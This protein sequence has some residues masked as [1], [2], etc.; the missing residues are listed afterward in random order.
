MKTYFKPTLVAT[1][2]VIAGASGA[3]SAGPL[4]QLYFQQTSTYASPLIEFNGEPAIS[5]TEA[6]EL[7]SWTSN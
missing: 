4:S 7:L 6:P 2:L 3:A 5:V 1:A